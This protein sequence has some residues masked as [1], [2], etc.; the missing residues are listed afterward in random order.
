MTHAQSERKVI[1]DDLIPNMQNTPLMSFPTLSREL[2]LTDYEYVFC[3]Y[4]AR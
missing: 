2:D 3:K 1:D 4:C